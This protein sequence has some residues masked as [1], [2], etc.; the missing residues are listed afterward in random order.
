MCWFTPQTTT[1]SRS[2][3]AEAKDPRARQDL[4][5]GWHRPKYRSHPLLPPKECINRSL[6]LEAGPRSG[7][8]YSNR[9]EIP[10]S[11]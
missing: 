8:R 11:G 10:K 9:C 7:S 5:Y 3:Q 1:T 4:S 2:G 6:E